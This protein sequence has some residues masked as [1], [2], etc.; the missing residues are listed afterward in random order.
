MTADCSGL[1]N[2]PRRLLTGRWSQSEWGECEDKPRQLPALPKDANGAFAAERL[3][4]Q[5]QKSVETLPLRRHGKNFKDF[6]S[7]HTHTPTNTHG[8]G[9]VA[10]PWLQPV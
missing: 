8:T 5:S 7:I 6:C 4:Q 9:V 10:H 2:A 3:S 1:I